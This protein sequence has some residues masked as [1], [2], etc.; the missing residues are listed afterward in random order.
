MSALWSMVGAPEVGA[1]R[2]RV[3]IVVAV[4][5]LAP[6][7]IVLALVPRSADQS[8][9]VAVVNLD[10][11]VGLTTDSPVIAGKLL[12]E[13]LV[14]T[15]NGVDWT[16][17]DT[18]TASTGLDDGTYVAVV[19]I[20]TDFSKSVATIS[21]DT[22]A[23]ATISV[24]T[25]TAHGYAGG[26]IADAV[27]ER[28]PNGVST[29]IT[30]AYI[31]GTLDSFAQLHTGI[32]EIGGG[33]SKIADDTDAASTGAGTI[34]GYSEDLATGLAD[35]RDVLGL[36]PDG[37]RDLG[38]LSADGAAGSAQLAEALGER[39]LR[40]SELA[41]AQTLTADALAELE[42]AIRA[43]PTA[44]MSDLLGTVVALQDEVD[45][46][47][48]QLYEQGGSLANDAEYAVGVAAADAVLADVSGPVARGLTTLDG[49]VGDTA[50]VSEAIGTGIATLSTDLGELGAAT[51]TVVDDLDTISADIP[52]YSAAQQKSIA[53]VVSTPITAD[54]TSVA[55]PTTARAATLGAVVPVALWLGALATFLVVAPFSR[56]RL[57][58]AV[59]A[60]RIAAD[61]AMVAVAVGFVQ[62]VLVWIAIVI[63]GIPATRLGVAFAFTV[64]A[65]MAFALLHQALVALMGRA[66]LVVSVVALGL[67]LV[68]SGTL[69]P[70]SSESALGFLPLSLALQGAQAL[71]GGSLHAVLSAAIGLAIWGV[72]A[73]LLTVAAVARA[74]QSVLRGMLVATAS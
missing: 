8:I 69:A 44:P 55:G 1:R 37:A 71:V 46:M 32:G 17:T 62:A 54:V 61:S 11:P 51:G 74:R 18:A 12:T 7:L 5:V 56:T 14:T 33:L 29:T 60:L 66:G 57:T 67:Q 68:A 65:A 6:L 49:Y 63:V 73:A 72:I 22:P 38:R 43:D 45:G 36:L 64:V 15:D 13:N 20:P 24:K 42:A 58:T 48:S 41:A 27:A 70:H 35:I 28:I 2:T 16:L 50:E 10:V 30:T 19:T 53:A 26:V 3:L 47:A 9:P 4:A 31:S 34:A 25:S 23:A 52:D 21:S 59:S 40:A 39:S